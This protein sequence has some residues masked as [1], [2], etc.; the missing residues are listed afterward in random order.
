MNDTSRIRVRDLL[1]CMM[2]AG[3][4][5]TVPATSAWRVGW[6][7][8]SRVLFA[9]AVGAAAPVA[10]QTGGAMSV[11]G[12]KVMPA[13]FK[14]DLRLLP[15]P[16]A[17]PTGQKFRWPRLKPPPVA[18]SGGGAPPAASSS[19][20]SGPHAPM[21]STLQNF[22]GISRNDSCTGGS[23]GGT[24]IPP[25]ANGEVG[26]NHYIEAVN[27]AYA[28]YT[29]TGTLLATF[30]EDQL[31]GY[32]PPPPPCLPTNLTCDLPHASGA[33]FACA[34]SSQ[35]D[36]IVV[37]DSIADRWV[38]AHVAFA[39]PT[40]P[41]YACIAA[42]KTSDPV[43]GGWWLYALQFDTGLPGQPPAGAL[44]DY[45]KFGVWHDCLYM[46]ANAFTN[47]TTSATYVGAAFASFSRADL[48]SGNPLTWS[49]GML[50][51]P[52]NQAFGMFPAH[53]VGHGATAVPPGTPEWFVHESLTAFDFHVRKFTPGPNCS[54]GT[55]SAPTLVP[56]ASYSADLADYGAVVQQPNTGNLLDN[57]AGEIMQ[58]VQ[59]RKV[60]SAESLWVVYTVP[61]ASI[62]AAL[63][64]AQLDVTGG[65]IGPTAVQQQIY[66]PDTTLYRFMPSLAVDRQGNVAIGFNTSGAS[67]PDFPSIKYVGRLASDPP[68][69]LPQ[70]EIPLIAGSGSQTV[71]CGA[72]SPGLCDR[73]GDYSGMSIDPVDEC[74]FWYANQ[75]YNSQANGDTGNWQTQIGSFKFPSC[76]ATAATQRT[77]V[78]SLGLDTNP[79]TPT[80]P[81]RQLAV[82][83][84]ATASG[85]EIVVLDSAGYGPL[86]IDRPV[87]IVAPPGVYAGI[88]VL[89]GHG[90]DVNP[91]PGNVTLRGLTINGLGGDIGINF[92]SGAALY[93]ENCLVTGFTSMGLQV[94]APAAANVYVRNSTFRGNFNGAFF[95][96]TSGATGVLR[97]Q[98]ERSV[99]ENNAT[100]GIGFTGGSTNATIA[101]SAFSGG[102][103]GLYVNPGIGGAVTNV[104]ARGT[105]ITKNATSGV[106]VG[107]VAGTSAVLNLASSQ[108]TGNGIGIE[109]LNGGT[110]YVTDTTITG[111]TT[112][113]THVAGSAVSLGDNRLTNNGTNGTFTSTSPKQ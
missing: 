62:K 83:L 3:V 22:S 42:S 8:I 104:E 30:T 81:C 89:S 58:K 71:D 87:T 57:L 85:G 112:G 7:A 36:P 69:T 109:T 24:A 95:G 72:P 2:P 41:F 92:M 54:A 10:A 33:A 70:S 73:W 13:E 78:S 76:T 48:Y 6:A 103:W 25:D 26:P 65:T 1:A 79:C 15:I 18:K 5:F 56:Q 16:A 39:S 20:L 88:S 46:G 28:I 31:W 105:T 34:G 96:T 61:L 12:P 45:P 107:G 110:A 106:R 67:T 53:S 99:F 93:I 63:Q 75:Y 60:G 64:W 37:Y 101:D 40:G 27:R 44:N 35:G 74:T 82:A 51:Y 43:A 94:L 59:Y 66:S 21:P 108:I 23:C 17:G 19:P 14:G 90:I 50:D 68:N 47:L 100:T 97:T 111:N 86:T 80:S 102:I 91:G 77:F 55:L 52:A 4:G 84:A 9:L 11:D 98:V 38:L 29:K 113:I 32:V 49:L